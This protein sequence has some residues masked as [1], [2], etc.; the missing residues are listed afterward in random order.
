M[1]SK[2]SKQFSKMKI[3]IIKKII[4]RP[5]IKHLP[6]QPILPPPPPRTSPPHPVHVH[7]D[8]SSDH[9]FS[10]D[11]QSELWSQ[12]SRDVWVYWHPPV[13]LR[14]TVIDIFFKLCIWTIKLKPW[15]LTQATNESLRIN[16]NARSR[17]R[18]GLR[19]ISWDGGTITVDQ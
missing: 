5:S 7:G 13:H 2:L 3:M 9:L 11:E 17:K 10:R 1:N 19:L 18:L 12:S 15:E 8:H 14:K 4:Q 16:I 6:N